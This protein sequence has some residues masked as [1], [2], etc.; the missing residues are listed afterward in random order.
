M[1]PLNVNDKLLI[2]KTLKHYTD[3]QL[4]CALE[5]PVQYWLDTPEAFNK[6]AVNGAG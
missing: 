1:I 4:R 5:W 3:D 6:W 2:N